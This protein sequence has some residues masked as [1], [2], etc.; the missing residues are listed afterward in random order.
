LIFLVV[1]VLE[2][3]RIVINE[4]II[5]LTGR[6]REFIGDTLGLAAALV[7]AQADGMAASIWAIHG[8]PAIWINPVAGIT[9]IHGMPAIN[10]RRGGKTYYILAIPG[11][12]TGIAG[13]TVKTAGFKVNIRGAILC[14]CGYF[15]GTNH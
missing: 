1:G 5:I 15:H 14:V 12:K 8:K 7:I 13:P 6:D 11:Y 9:R 10:R 4:R 2:D 3:Y